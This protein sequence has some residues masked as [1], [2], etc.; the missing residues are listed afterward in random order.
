MRQQV[1][2]FKFVHLPNKSPLGAELLLKLFGG[3]FGVL[4]VI[5]LISFMYETHLSHK[6][7]EVK[8]TLE[9][10]RKEL[11]ALAG[12]FPQSNIPTQI[13]DATRAPICNTKFSLFLQ[14]FANA[15]V[16]GVWLT[17]FSITK[18]GQEVLIRGN[19]TRAL[20][21]QQYLL[22]LKQQPELA[23]LSFAI[24]TLSDATPPINFQVVGRLPPHG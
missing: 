14:A 24:Q 11:V 3:F 18:S 1:N 2:L 12:Q 5:F 20:Q 7:E 8:V 13:L 6:D 10:K 16:G 15:Y 4:M 19:A 9:A 23:K 17:E 21:V 22:Q